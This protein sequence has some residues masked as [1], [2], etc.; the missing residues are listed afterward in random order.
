MYRSIR[1]IPFLFIV[2]NLFSQAIKD[3]VRENVD[4]SRTS[5]MVQREGSSRSA[6]HYIG[7]QANQL[8]RQLL[9]LSGTSASI[10]NPYTA[11]YSFNGKQKGNGMAFG[12]GI[13][14]KKISDNDQG[15]NRETINND[16]FFR[17][18]YDKKI[19]LNQRWIWGWGVDGLLLRSKRN[20]TTSF[21]GTLSSVI[22]STENGFGFGPRVSLLFNISKMVYLGTEASCYYQSSKTKRE[23]KLD[24]NPPRKDDTKNSTFELQVP[25]VIFLV[26][27]F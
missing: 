1:L 14:S 25:V 21:Q 11:S 3:T 2:S 13:L 9:N 7:L 15:I 8:L 24:N 22:N 17:V 16:F 26:V 4:Y 23:T 27:R 19:Q 6:N 5:S 10:N 12:L 20:T 18:G